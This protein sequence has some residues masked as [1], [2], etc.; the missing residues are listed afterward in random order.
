MTI[1]YAGGLHYGYGDQLRRMLPVLRATGTRVEYFGPKPAGANR[2]LAE[3]TDVFHCNGYVSPPEAVWREILKRCD[4]VLQPYSNPLGQHEL[5]CRT[6]FPSKLTDYLS[7]GLPVI[8]TGPA[9]ASGIAWCL[10]HPA[11]AMTITDPAPAALIAGLRELAADATL[12]ETLARGAHAAAGEFDAGPLRAQLYNAL[13]D[14][15]AAR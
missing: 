14:A 9:E 4:A 8:V 10:R 2:V 15:A 6:H 12:R 11:S 1:G 5:Q 7:L 3:A 13:T